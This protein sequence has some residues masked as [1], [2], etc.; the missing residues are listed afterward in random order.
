[1]KELL[2]FIVGSLV[3]NKEAIKIDV[4]E[5]DRFI[6]CLVLVD[7]TDLGKVVGRNGKIATAI[8][9]V[10]RASARKSDKRVNIKIDKN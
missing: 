5:N 4:K 1:M 6:D 3:D 8:R 9:T 7:E 2:E 10:A